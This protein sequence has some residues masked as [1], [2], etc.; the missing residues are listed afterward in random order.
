MNKLGIIGGIGPEATIDYYT[1]IIKG[2]QQAQGTQ[3]A[4][5]ELAI[6]SINMYHM[7]D[8]LDQKKYD[9][10]A[11]YVAA[12]ANHLKQAGADFGLMC[13]NTPHIVFDQIQARTSLPL[14]SIVEASLLR[15]QKLGLHHLGLLGTKFTMQN[16]FFSGPFR[17]AG[18][19]IVLPTAAEQTLIHQKI[20]DEL[21]NGIVKPATKKQLLALIENL[22]TMHHLDGIILGC[23]EL[24][25]IIQPA[26]LTTSVFNIAQIHIE[27]AV[28]RIMAK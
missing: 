7:F 9:A 22:V 4:L 26:D 28:E 8:L 10:V 24:P 5:P 23:T 6:D 11:D 17:R 25:L 16:D 19:E 1:G 3:K 27:T 12:A 14:L 21:E 2:W 15:A 20:V 13:G 18:I